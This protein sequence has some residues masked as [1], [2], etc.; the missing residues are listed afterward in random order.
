MQYPMVSCNHLTL[1]HKKCSLIPMD[2]GSDDIIAEEWKGM[3]LG[4]KWV[5][6]W[7]KIMKDASVSIMLFRK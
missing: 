6:S 1:D 3:W 4:V 2:T 7:F 5:T